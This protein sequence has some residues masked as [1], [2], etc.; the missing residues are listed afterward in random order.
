MTQ[1]TDD[2]DWEEILERL[3]MNFAD[4]PDMASLILR[5][6]QVLGR[7]ATSHQIDLTV[8]V[9]QTQAQRA[10]DAGFSIE[11]FRRR[12]QMVTMIRGPL[13]RFVASTEIAIDEVRTITRKRVGNIAAAI[14]RGAG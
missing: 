2:Y 4:F 14:A 6:D 5:L 11:R 12:G 7:Q 13:G 9:L 10:V 1:R 8:V 3:D